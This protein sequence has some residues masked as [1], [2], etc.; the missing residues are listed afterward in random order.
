MPFEIS[1]IREIN[2]YYEKVYLPTYSKLPQE[3]FDNLAYN[4]KALN[5][6]TSKTNKL[7][8]FYAFDEFNPNNFVLGGKRIKITDKLVPVSIQ[9]R[10][11]LSLMFEALLNKYQPNVLS[12]FNKNLVEPRI[13]IFKKCIIACERAE[14]PLTKDIKGL[15]SIKTSC[16]LVGLKT[17]WSLVNAQFHKFRK[18]IPKMDVRIAA[19]QKYLNEIE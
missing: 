13:K 4:F 11:D 16:D 8:R 7:N 9:N 19:I 14:L 15:H 12:R 18:T 5:N 6:I 17:P 1:N 10:N 3:L 2:A